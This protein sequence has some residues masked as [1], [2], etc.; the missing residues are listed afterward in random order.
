MQRRRASLLSR[1]ILWLNTLLKAQFRNDL[2][3]NWIYSMHGHISVSSK[4][5]HNNN[6]MPNM[7]PGMDRVIH[8]RFFVSPSKADLAIRQS[9][10]QL[11][12]ASRDWLITHS[13]ASPDFKQVP[14]EASI[15]SSCLYWISCNL[16]EAGFEDAFEDACLY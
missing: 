13:S 15:S 5:N 10:G 7:I 9:V 8:C 16:I 2:H 11:I 6:C 12:L 4:T 3:N 14:G 1:E